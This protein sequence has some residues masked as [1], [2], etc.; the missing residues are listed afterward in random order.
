MAAKK[1]STKKRAAAKRVSPQAAPR[2]AKV[3]PREPNPLQRHTR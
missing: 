3:Q 1:K 2:A